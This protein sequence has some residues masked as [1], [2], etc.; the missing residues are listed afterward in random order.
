MFYDHGKV[1][2]TAGDRF[3]GVNQLRLQRQ[4]PAVLVPF[5]LF[6]QQ[7]LNGRATKADHRPSRSSGRATR[8]PHRLKR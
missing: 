2:H 5:Q 3:N 8:L 4:R 6:H 1:R 7:T